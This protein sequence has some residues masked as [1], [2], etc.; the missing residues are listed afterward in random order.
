M[1]VVRLQH[2][3]TRPHTSAQTTSHIG[4]LG[5][6]VAEHPAYSPDLAPSDFHWFPKLKEH[7]RGRYYESDEEVKAVVKKW[8]RNQGEHFFS[9]GINKLPGRWEV[10][11]NRDGDYVEK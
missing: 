3:N 7:L 11:I 10:C 6:E 8:F 5:F 9:N 1:K 2:D 4:R